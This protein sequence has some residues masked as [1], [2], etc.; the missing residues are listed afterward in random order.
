MNEKTTQLAN[1]ASSIATA[2]EHLN[3]QNIERIE[4]SQ[5]KQLK[6]TADFILTNANGKQ[7]TI[8]VKTKNGAFTLNNLG[9]GTQAAK[10]WIDDTKFHQTL[11]TVQGNSLQLRKD[12]LQNYQRW[13]DISDMEMQNKLRMKV[14]EPFLNF[15]Y[16]Q[17]S[18]NKQILTKFM[19]YLQDRD[20]DLT[21]ITDRGEVIETRYK[22]YEAIMKITNIYIKN[23]SIIVE[24]YYEFRFKSEGGAIKSS[25]KINVQPYKNQVAPPVTS[26]TITSPQKPKII[27]KIRQKPKII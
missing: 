14:I 20:S 16:Q 2:I 10:Q 19:F 1:E 3:N 24:P 12:I 5:N 23:K 9:T 27:I 26:A 4:S 18:Q 7:Q 6:T 15:Y 13:G 8:S 17:F 22:T 11:K 21:L 25:I